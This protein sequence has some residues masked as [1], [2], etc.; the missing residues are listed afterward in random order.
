MEVF[1]VLLSIAVAAF[2]TEYPH[3]AFIVLAIV[4]GLA[5]FWFIASFIEDRITAKEQGIRPVQK[6]YGVALSSIALAIFVLLSCQPYFRNAETERRE[7]KEKAEREAKMKEIS[8]LADR[9]RR[10][11]ADQ[12]QKIQTEY[13]Q[14]KAEWEKNQKKNS[15]SSGSTHYSYRKN[16]SSSSSYFLDPDEYDS[17]E[18]Y[19]DDAWGYDFDDW[20]D[21]DSYWENW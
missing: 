2:V 5:A 15:S 9:I 3:S 18:E 10:E 8:E 13:E 12:K 19:M 20:D 16:Q 4:S 21:A 6:G 17:Y 1:L 7:A 11:E 14:L